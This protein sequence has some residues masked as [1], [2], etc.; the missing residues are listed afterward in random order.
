MHAGQRCQP[1]ERAVRV[2]C[3]QIQPGKTGKQPAP[4]PVAKYPDSGKQYQTPGGTLLGKL[5]PEPERQ[6]VE[7]RQPCNKEN[8]QQNGNRNGG[9]TVFADTDV[10][11]AGAAAEQPQASKPTGP[12]EL[13]WSQRN[14]HEEN[15][16]D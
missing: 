2:C 5:A 13:L 14:R 1:G 7:Q 15:K 9:I 10:D 3:A 16:K 8:R 4:K 6:T 11:P 12:E